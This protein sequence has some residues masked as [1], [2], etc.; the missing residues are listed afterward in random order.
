MS[1]G[2]LTMDARMFSKACEQANRAAFGICFIMFLF[3]FLRSQV[4]SPPLC[5]AS[6]SG[7]V[8][9][10]DIKLLSRFSRQTDNRDPILSKWWLT[11]PN[12]WVIIKVNCA[13]ALV[14]FSDS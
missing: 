4:L 8:E 11:R 13:I 7:W 2:L 14:S 1:S 5:R 3:L 10:A 6:V 12:A 9:I